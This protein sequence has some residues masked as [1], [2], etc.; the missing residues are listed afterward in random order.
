MAFVAVMRNKA[1]NCQ[2]VLVVT[3]GGAPLSGDLAVSAGSHDRRY[4]GGDELRAA[5][6]R[7]T[8]RA[9][10]AKVPDALG[11]LRRRNGARDPNAPPDRSGGREWVRK[12]AGQTGRADHAGSYLGDLGGVEGPRGRLAPCSGTCSGEWR[13]CVRPPRTSWLP[14]CCRHECSPATGPAWL[15]F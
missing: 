5:L 12:E 2:R 8:A 6:G 13:L 11:D 4:R 9:L 15:K 10:Q 3:D 14:R 1:V 7:A